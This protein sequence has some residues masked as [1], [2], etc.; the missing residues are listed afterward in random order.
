M[1]NVDNPGWKSFVKV[2]C[3]TGNTFCDWRHTKSVGHG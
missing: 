2:G 3:G 1:E